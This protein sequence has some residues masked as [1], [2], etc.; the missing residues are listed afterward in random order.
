[1]DINFSGLLYAVSYALDCVE[2]EL[3]GVSAGHA[4]RVACCCAAMGNKMGMSGD[5]RMDLAAYACLHD[6]ALT[7]Y[8]SEELRSYHSQ[9]VTSLRSHCLIGER[10][11]VKFPFIKKRDNII[12]YHHETAD[13][14][15][16]F[17]KTADETPI[18]SQLV[19]IADMVDVQYNLGDPGDDKYENICEFLADTNPKV[20]KPVL[21]TC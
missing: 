5:E 10:N 19:H 4:K 21:K 6:N 7:Q 16:P 15:G 3:T 9:D 20:V 17:G 2:S 8:I 11:L 18:F 1:M 12:M 14:K 13:G